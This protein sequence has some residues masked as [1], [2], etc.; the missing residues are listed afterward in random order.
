MTSIILSTVCALALNAASLS[1]QADTADIYLIDYVKV[2]NFNGS[3]L[4]SKVIYSYTIRRSTVSGVP[5]RLHFINTGVMKDGKVVYSPS[6]QTPAVLLY[7]ENFNNCTA[8]SV[9][10]PNTASD[11]LPGGL[12]VPSITHRTAD[13]APSTVNAIYVVDG[14]VVSEEDYKNLD[15]KKISS[16]N[17][18][19]DAS[20]ISVIRELTAQGKYDGEIE[21][22][23]AV[24]VITK[25]KKK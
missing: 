6:S 25:Q 11:N 1:A 14:I 19:K 12:Q 3:Q 4:A 10:K 13:A 24:V 5:T 23:N 21:G 7:D 15:P 17:I 2:E 22:V 16:I 18:A 9:E 8:V 20:S